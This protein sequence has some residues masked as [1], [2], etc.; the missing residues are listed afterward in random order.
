MTFCKFFDISNLR[1]FKKKKFQT[2]VEI[3]FH[4]KHTGLLPNSTMTLYREFIDIPALCRIVAS[5]NNNCML[6]TCVC[7]KVKTYLYVKKLPLCL[8][9]FLLSFCY[10]FFFVRLMKTQFIPIIHFCLAQN[11][12]I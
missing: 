4:T 3:K 5:I 10:V 7:E 1:I 9:D 8:M 11:Y 12:I 2:I 6:Y